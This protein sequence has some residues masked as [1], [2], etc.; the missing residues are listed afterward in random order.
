ML[1]L[2]VE[3]GAMPKLAQFDR[4]DWPKLIWPIFQKAKMD[5]N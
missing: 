5:R 3:T 4:D 2:D 1:T